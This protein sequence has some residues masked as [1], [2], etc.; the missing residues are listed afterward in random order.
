MAILNTLFSAQGLSTSGGTLTGDVT[1][2]GDLT[3]EGSA[4]NGVYDEII[5]GSLKIQTASASQTAS[6]D[7]DELLLENSGN[8][9][10]TI[11]SGTSNFGNIFFGDSGSA[12][13][14][15][16]RYY[17][18]DNLDNCHLHNK[19]QPFYLSNVNG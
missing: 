12:S 13:I 4:A 11:L 10:L 6:V 19:I 7:A 18:N 2:A 17:H 14:G 1:I 15:Y 3:V 8:A 5:E 16:I 9:G